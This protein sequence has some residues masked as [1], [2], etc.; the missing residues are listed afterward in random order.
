MRKVKKGETVKVAVV[1]GTRPEAIK[2]APVILELKRHSALFEPL[3]CASGQHREML[4]QALAAFG[5]EPQY[6]L[7]VMRSRQSLSEVTAAVLGGLEPIFTSEQPDV[8]IV[9]GDTTTAFAASLAAYY[10]GIPVGH[11]EAGLRTEDK[12][13][14]FPEEI[15]RRLITHIA[16]LHFAPTEIARANL[17]REAIDAARIVVTGNTV[18]DAL[19]F[20]R[21]RLARESSLRP[22]FG[23]DGGNHP[24]IL[25]TAHRRESFG[26]PLQ[27][28]CR[29][30]RTLAERRPD[31]SIVYPVHLN[32][33]VAEPVHQSLSGLPN[34]KLLSPLDYVSF[35]ALMDRATILL[36]DSGGLQEEGPSLGKPVLVMRDTSERPEAIDAG[37]AWLVGTD[38]QRIM[39]AVETLLDE[40]QVYQHMATRPNPFGDGHAAE[41]IVSALSEWHHVTAAPER[42]PQ[43]NWPEGLS[44]SPGASTS[45]DSLRLFRFC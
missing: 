18:V 24:V 42:D 28:I 19:H 32:P 4:A 44:P 15:N 12:Y 8:V 1:L 41:R 5:L 7:D 35:V 31:V 37:A 2:L 3:V 14:P 30:I 10:Q 11:V 34:I 21:R 22:D 26:Q 25:V 38:P 29:A 20:I 43:R 45:L 9:Q 6:N 36:T 17:L 39:T 40:P 16:E 13:S 33:N 23:L 27:Q